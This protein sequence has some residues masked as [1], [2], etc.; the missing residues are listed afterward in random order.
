MIWVSEPYEPTTSD[1]GQR[2]AADISTHKKAIRIAVKVMPFIGLGLSIAMVVW[3]KQA[4]I[5]DSLDSLQAYIDSLGIWGPIGF[6]AASFAS[7][8][9]PIIPAGLLVIAAPI[10]FGPIDGT[11][12]NWLSV[13]AGSLVNFIVARQVGM[14]L[15]DAMFS[16]RT[17]EKYLGW[18]RKKGF[19]TAFA[20]AIVLPVA[21]DDL[22]CYLAGTTKM[23]FST[24]TAIILLGKIPTLV[25]YGLGV[26]ALVTSFIPW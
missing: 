21:P 4:G 8:M 7:V 24:Y 16:E 13:C 5:L 6:M 23:K 18:T 11:V 25:A 22:L 12:Y 1:F 15:I 17:V 2:A 26:S 10:L 19:T 9:F 3:G 14:P 20:T